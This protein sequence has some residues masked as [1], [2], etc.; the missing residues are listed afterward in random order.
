MTERAF[1]RRR[2][3]ELL[4]P[5]VLRAEEVSGKRQ[6]HLYDALNTVRLD[7]NLDVQQ[8]RLL[9]DLVKQAGWTSHTLLDSIFRE[10]SER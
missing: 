3:R 10:E 9:H 8:Q 4:E 2:L 7:E 1:A 5:Y 6:P